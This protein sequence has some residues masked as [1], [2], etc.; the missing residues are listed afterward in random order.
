MSDGLVGEED[1][2]VGADDG[3]VGVLVGTMVEFS[4]QID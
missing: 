4:I 1:G 2:L 3:L